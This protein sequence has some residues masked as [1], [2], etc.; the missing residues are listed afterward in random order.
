VLRKFRS[1]ATY[2][3]VAATLAL[4]LALGGVSYAALARN[5]VFSR[6]ITNGEVKP[7]DLNATA[8]SARTRHRSANT[9]SINQTNTTVAELTN[10]APGTYLVMS[11]VS[12]FQTAGTG[13]V[14]CNLDAGTQNDRSEAY[15]DGISDLQLT[16]HL[17][18][19]FNAAGTATLSCIRETA[20]QNTSTNA[21][22]IT[23]VRLTSHSSTAF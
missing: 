5:S 3:N 12:L 2:S 16:N 9:G 13:L 10:I 14:N 11:K 21:A 19:K 17:T 8:V 6:H 18:V 23:V 15:L 4:V 20:G 22:R 7:A 1:M